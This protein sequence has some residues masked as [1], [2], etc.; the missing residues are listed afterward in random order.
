MVH[1]DSNN[2]SEESTPRRQ[3]HFKASQN[4]GSSNKP[5]AAIPPDVLN[6]NHNSTHKSNDQH[7]LMNELPLDLNLPESNVQLDVNG[8]TS[9][10]R[11]FK[12]YSIGSLR[13]RNEWHESEQSENLPK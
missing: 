13:N 6:I 7:V 8:S 12:D 3:L 10:S 1:N 9:D 5:I 2:V 4:L 11:I